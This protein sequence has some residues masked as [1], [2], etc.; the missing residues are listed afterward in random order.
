MHRCFFSTCSQIATLS[1]AYYVFKIEKGSSG[2]TMLKETP[3][4]DLELSEKV[5]E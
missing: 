2:A 5:A 4:Q 1:C 3:G